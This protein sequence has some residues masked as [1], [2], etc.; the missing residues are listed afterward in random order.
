M[1]FDIPMCVHVVIFLENFMLIQLL[2]I[3]LKVMVIL[4]MVIILGNSIL[5]IG[6]I[7][8]AININLNLI[9]SL[10][11]FLV[12]GIIYSFIVIKICDYIFYFFED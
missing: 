5:A 11:L 7:M 9:Q 10:S 12:I 4:F 3:I 8:N 6:L 2:K 1:N